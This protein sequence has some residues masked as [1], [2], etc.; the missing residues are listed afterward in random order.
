LFHGKPIWFL[1]QIG[2]E[3][4]DLI[5]LMDVPEHVDDDVGLMRSALVGAAEHAYML[6]TVPAFQKLFSAHDIFLEHKRRYTL[7]Q[8]EQVV[9]GGRFGDPVDTIF[10]RLPAS[11]CGYAEALKAAERG[12]ERS[13]TALQTGQFNALLASPPGI[14]ALPIQSDRGPHRLLPGARPVT[15]SS[16]P[17]LLSIIVPTCNEEEGLREFNRCLVTV[18]RSLP[19]SSE[20]VY[21]ND[22]SK[23]GTLEILRSLSAEHDN[24]TVVDLSGNFG[25]EIA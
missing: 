22:G 24:I 10:L 25:K 5:L 19:F 13:E 9:Q 11:D 14:A 3:K 12:E 18:L 23:D 7:R 2:D 20:I 6:I 1:R 8:V 17:E 21:V 4:C 16:G 15:D